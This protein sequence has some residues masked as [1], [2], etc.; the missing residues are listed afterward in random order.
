MSR[1]DIRLVQPS[2]TSWVRSWKHIQSICLL[3]HC[4]DKCFWCLLIQHLLSCKLKSNSLEYKTAK[5]ISQSHGWSM[6]IR[7]H[8]PIH[9]VNYLNPFS[10]LQN[11]PA[12][13]LTL[14]NLYNFTPHVYVVLLGELEDHPADHQFC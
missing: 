4:W 10:F 14:P 2:I 12:F 11:T 1:R 6:N 3:I 9:Q 8:H 7:K 13:K 5:E